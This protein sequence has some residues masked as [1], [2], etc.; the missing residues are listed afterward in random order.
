[1][2]SLLAG[3]VL[4]PQLGLWASTSLLAVA[5]VIAGAAVGLRGS[6]IAAGVVTL[7][8]ALALWVLQPWQ[9]PL[10]RLGPGESLVA[11]YEGAHASIAV[12]DDEHGRA[13][14]LN[15]YYT[16]A[17]TGL[18]MD[19][20]RRGHLPLLLHPNPEHVIFL[21]SATGLTAAAALAHPEVRR[22]ELVEI[23]PEVAEA[24]RRDF[25]DW[26]RAVYD[27]GATRVRLEDARNHMRLTRDRYD[28]VVGE[29]FVP[30]NPGA[31][32]LFTREHFRAVQSRLADGG[33]YCQWLPLHQLGRRSF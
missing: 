16:L 24:A 15:N 12:V 29:L 6:P 3:F 11:V 14:R 5:Y 18:K 32:G 33:L 28:V 1:M 21:G 31:S 27:A 7:A 26:N 10:V 23:V 20:A 9:A 2:G 22:I 8:A 17:G 4:I 13:M 30:W 19:E 25:A